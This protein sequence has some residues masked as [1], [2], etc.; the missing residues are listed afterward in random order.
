LLLGLALLGVSLPLDQAG[1]AVPLWQDVIAAGIAVAS[2][3]VFFSMPMNMLLWPVAVGM[4]A[5]AVRWAALTVLGFSAAIG[6]LVA[7]LVVGLI[8]TPVSRREHMPFAAIGFASVVSM[9]P[10]VYIFRMASGLVQIA[11]GRQ[12]TLELISATI[13]D[14]ITA[15]MIICAM[16]FGLIA[17]KLVIDYLGDR[18]IQ[19]R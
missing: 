3:G 6:A 14:G 16:S 5:H 2:Y 11:G 15:M 1:R 4:L 10:G 18:T 8:L 13:A 12:T 17:P 9:M 19:R 7:C